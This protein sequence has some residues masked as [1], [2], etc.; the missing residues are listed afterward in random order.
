MWTDSFPMALRLKAD[1][2]LT[3]VD[4]GKLLLVVKRPALAGWEH[5]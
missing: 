4:A 1:V 2:H 3:I 5:F